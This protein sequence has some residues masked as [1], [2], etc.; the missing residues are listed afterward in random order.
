MFL[1]SP[2]EAALQTP[3]IP[4]SLDDTTRGD[5]RGA[6]DPSPVPAPA[7]DHRPDRLIPVSYTHLDVYKR[8]VLLQPIDDIR[9]ICHFGRMRYQDDAFILFFCKPSKD[10]HDLF[11]GF[12][13]EIA[14][15]LI[16]QDDFW[17]IG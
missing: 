13:I 1:Q 9:S 16:R 4:P 14:G 8:Q 10:L 3:S 17:I 12:G 11:L 6:S 15:W 7:W 5:M 2:P